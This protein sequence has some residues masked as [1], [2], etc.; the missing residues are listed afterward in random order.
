MKDSAIIFVIIVMVII[1]N[2]ISQNIL[3][4]DS[5]NLT[6]KLEDLKQNI[7]Q[8]E[9]AKEKVNEIY[10]LW[11][12]I[13]SRWSIIITHQELD[14]IKTAILTIKAGIEVDD[15]QI[16]YEQIENSI[17]LVGHIK[18]KEALSLKNIF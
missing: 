17:F 16:A 12:E 15:H 1:G 8:K 13:D 7:N 2:I 11:E 6:N 10:E 9:L 14:L 3:K 4:Q 18:E 5:E